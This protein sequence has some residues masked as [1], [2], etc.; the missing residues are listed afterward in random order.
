MQRRLLSNLHAATTWTPKRNQNENEQSLRQERQSHLKKAATHPRDA[1]KARIQVLQQVSILLLLHRL[2]SL[3][4][5]ALRDDLLH[6]F[7]LRFAAAVARAAAKVVG[8]ECGIERRAVVVVSIIG[9][10]GVFE[11][12]ELREWVAEVRER[13]T[14]VCVARCVSVPCQGEL[15]CKR[16]AL[17][18]KVFITDCYLHV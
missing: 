8:S 5:L 3:G 11:V 4:G 14:A 7:L 17:L 1:R 16:V 2:G 15:A 9:A 13:C 10:D 6:D 12:V 18:P